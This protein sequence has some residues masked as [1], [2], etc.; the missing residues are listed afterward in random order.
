MFKT[1]K[2]LEMEKFSCEKLKQF[3]TEYTSRRELFANGNH[4]DIV[5]EYS[6]AQLLVAQ[7]MRNKK[8]DQ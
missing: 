4:W 5:K 3:S 6:D 2:E 7:V 8:C 1:S